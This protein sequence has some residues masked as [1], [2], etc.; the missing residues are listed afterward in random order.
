MLQ[1]RSSKRHP[2]IEVFSS[3]IHLVLTS[4]KF[5]LKLRINHEQISNLIFQSLESF[6]RES[7]LEY[8]SYFFLFVFRYH[9][10]YF[11]SIKLLFSLFN[12]LF[13]ILIYI[14][15]CSMLDV[16]V[17]LQSIVLS[18]RQNSCI[19]HDMLF[20]QGYRLANGVQPCFKFNCL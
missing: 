18:V 3:V 20:V 7:P 6:C 5:P 19:L 8:L 1:F 12:N 15:I 4:P 9:A 16:K 14:N 11:Y 10:S 13:F 17:R 2:N